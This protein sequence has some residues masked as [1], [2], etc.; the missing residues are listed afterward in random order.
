MSTMLQNMSIGRRLMIIIISINLLT[1]ILI[2]WVAVTSNQQSLEVQ[3][4]QR[5]TEKNQQAVQAISTELEN[6]IT[7]ANQLQVNLST[8]QSYSQVQ[9]RTLIRDILTQDSDKL[10][11][12]VAVYRPA[13]DSEDETG[14]DSIVVYQD[15]ESGFGASNSIRTYIADNQQPAPSSPMF[16]VLGQGEPIWFK[17]DI[18]YTDGNNL[19]AISLALPYQFMGE[20]GGL[21]W[22][23]VI[24]PT[25]QSMV[26]QQLNQVA[27]LSNTQ[28]GFAV[29]IDANGNI[30]SQQ[31]NRGDEVTVSLITDIL[32]RTLENTATLENLIPIEDP[33]TNE[34]Q[35]VAINTLDV[36]GWQFI[37]ILPREDV[38]ISS[39]ILVLQM[40]A[41][42][43]VGIVLMILAINYFARNSI[44]KPLENLSRAA[45]EI[46]SGDLRYHIAYRKYNDEI[47]YLARAMEGMKGNISH[48]YNELRAWSRT[49]EARVY[50]RTKEL[51]AT[52]KEA[53]DV[54]N[55]L[56]A[57]YDE[58]LMV[59]NEPTLE[60]IL[61]ALVHRI[62]SLLSAS[63]CSIWLVDETG[64]FLQ[65]VNN[66]E[67]GTITDF[68]I[69]I[70]EGLVGKS[71]SEQSVLTTDDYSEYDNPV[72]LP[73]EDKAPYVRAMVAPLMF[74]GN[75]MGAVFAGR[76]ADGEPFTDADTRL[77]SLFS[78]LVSPA[79]RNAQLF[80]QREEAR[81][82]AERANHV[83]TR[84]LA[85]VT[86][87]L[88]TPLNLIINNMDFMRIGAFGDVT[89]DQFSRLNQTVRSA[90]HL[91]YLI[92]DLLDVSKIEAGEMQLFI[93]PSDVQTII[94]DTVDSAY[95][96]IEKIEDKAERVELVVDVADNLPKLPIDARRIRQVITNLLT[97]AIKFTH[98]GTVTLTVK[99]VD[100]G[101]YFAVR[102]TGIGI[103]DNE[104]Q[105]LFEAFER[106]TQAKEQAIEG[107]GLGLPISQFLVQQHGSQIE[108]ESIE[109]EGTTFM[110]TLLFVMPTSD[111]AQE[112]AVM[113]ALK[114]D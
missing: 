48:S 36:N 114:S 63:Y 46:G 95:A 76:D 35:W 84:F 42:S 37:S 66:T 103:P 77:L 53:E 58:S 49:L 50:E 64:Q 75:P 4:R 107:T 45:Q 113:S 90:E 24:E 6:I 106:T 80:T 38:P 72:I 82:D 61:E 52:R 99:P 86:H 20:S 5:F 60:P 88:R 101:I 70:D 57:V 17:Q 47:G 21:V 93:Q 10:I 62:L 105:L 110:F 27:L 8:L 92:N 7:T 39:G 25:F 73:F 98:D 78:N 2:G 44:V 11:Q 3:A 91:L 41:I 87:E 30:L 40:I 16:E 14:D 15:F 111:D 104:K 68:V 67:D 18:A 9:L 29:L 97:N 56:Q 32:S 85:S 96:F 74:D 112:Q 12:R 81:R 34:Q 43:T 71:I 55:D 89:D 19:G 1:L 22:V 69:P 13:L 31:G 83:K 28:S 26:T 108:V 23:D 109:G 54:A 33:I 51:N 59:V 94:E 100:E 102:D 65:L 79:V